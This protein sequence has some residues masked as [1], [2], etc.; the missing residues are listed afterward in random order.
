MRRSF[1]LAMLA[2]LLPTCPL[3]HVWQKHRVAGAC[4]WLLAWSIAAQSQEPTTFT[5]EQL[6]ADLASI[7]SAL[8]RTHPDVSHSVDPAVLAAAF[9]DVRSKLDRPMTADEA[10]KVMSGLNPVMADGHLT[11]LYAGGVA[12][13]VQRHLESGGRLFP[14]AVHVTT[15]AAIFVRSGVD[16]SPT[17]FDGK[18]IDTINGVPADEIARKL[19]AH[20]NGDTPDL[21]AAW[22][23]ER[24]AFWYWKFFGEHRSFRLRIGGAE[25]VVEA[26][27]DTPSAYGEKTFER[28]FRFELLEGKAALLTIDEFY[29]SDKAK[30][31]E[32]TRAAFARMRDEGTRTLIIDIRSNGGGDDDVWIEGLLPYIATQPFR[33][34]STY[35]LKIIEGR[36]KEGQKVGDVVH[37]AQETVY[38]PQ[39]DHPLRF[40]GKVHV[41]ISPRTYSSAVLFSTV[42][43][44]NGFG[45]LVGVGGGARGT[46]SGGIQF[47]KLP[48]T[49]MTLVVPRFLLTRTSGR[50]GLLQP[51]VLVVGDP[52][53]PR[54]AIES[55]LRLAQKEPSQPSTALAHPSTVHPPQ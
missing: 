12:A 35:L 10:W 26:S 38:A 37:G 27:T 49:Q 44:D 4:L 17:P 20:M 13:E 47:I 54:A 16:G 8:D 36:A 15:S 45:T 14:Y 43:Q 9:D 30:F 18:R 52:F 25:S 2:Y 21:R 34:G 39:L 33:N 46:Q 41:L 24:F 3:G 40:K 19:L 55:I 42:V 7:Q 11:V 5:P 22:L 32:F 23:S 53:R 51:D 50:G 28:L 1:W 29:W 48:H 6:R 31:Y